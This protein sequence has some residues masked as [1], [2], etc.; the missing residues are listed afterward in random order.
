MALT[1]RMILKVFSCLGERLPGLINYVCRGCES[2]ELKHLCFI[3]VTPRS[4]VISVPFW[5]VFFRSF[6]NVIKLNKEEV[7]I[8]YSIHVNVKVTWIF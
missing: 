3:V 7:F 4:P 1:L 2:G 8:K 5:S 6:E